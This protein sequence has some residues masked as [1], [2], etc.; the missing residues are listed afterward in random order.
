MHPRRTLEI[1][2]YDDL[3]PTWKHKL[4]IQR[5]RARGV[6]PEDLAEVQ[7][8]VILAVLNYRHDPT[9]GASEKSALFTIID[10]QIS[11]YQRTHARRVALHE[12]F[13]AEQAV[14][15]PTEGVSGGQAQSELRMDL[16]TALDRLEPRDRAIC[17]DLAHGISYSRI[18]RKCG[19]SRHGLDLEIARIRA[20][21]E[22]MGIT[23]EVDE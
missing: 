4:I 12:R 15:T 18:A 20:R 7:Q 17:R 22:Q 5:A 23:G 6:P 3:L 10:R 21:L 2:T 16:Q 1:N 11:Q 14:F 19:V 13:A 8:E 9:K